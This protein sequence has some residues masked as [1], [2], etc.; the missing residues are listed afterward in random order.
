MTSMLPLIQ[1]TEYYPR[2]KFGKS[3]TY[4][5]GNEDP[6]QGSYQGNTAAPPIWQRISSLLTNTQ[7]HAGHRMPIVLS[8]TKKTHSQ[9]GIL[10][11]DAMHVWEGLGEGGDV[12]PT[13]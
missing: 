6:K 13:L 2:T 7:K 10:F 11:V 12:I 4:S 8:I 1:S 5:G 3:T 9:F